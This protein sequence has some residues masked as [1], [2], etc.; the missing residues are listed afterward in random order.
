MIKPLP[1]LLPADIDFHHADVLHELD[2]IRQ[3][4]LRSR[5]PECNPVRG[6]QTPHT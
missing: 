4:M 2:E 3:T 1:V 5:K 6:V